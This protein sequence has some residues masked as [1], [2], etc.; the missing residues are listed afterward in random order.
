MTPMATQ[1]FSLYVFMSLPPKTHSKIY[2]KRPTHQNP[3]TP[4]KPYP[5]S[6]TP[7]KSIFSLLFYPQQLPF[8]AFS[9][10]IV[11]KFRT[12]LFTHLKL[13]NCPSNS[14]CFLEQAS[15]RR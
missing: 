8:P 5:I 15:D 11:N 4:P 7:M 14:T 12:Q 6:K 1:Y 10:P 2:P 9:S 13:H 3:N